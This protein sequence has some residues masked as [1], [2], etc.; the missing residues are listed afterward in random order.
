MTSNAKILVLDDEA[1]LRALLQRYLTQHGFDVRAIGE[2]A[3]IDRLLQRESFDI[4][5]LDIMMRGED[6]LS[7]CQRLRAQKE[8]IPI[9]MLTARGEAVDRILGREVGA[10]DY[11]PKPFDPRELLACINALL[12]RQR[13]LGE[14]QRAADVRPLRLGCFVFDPSSRRL[15]RG[16]ELVSLTSGE[17][18]LLGALA[19]KAGRP[20]SRERL[21]EL[22]KGRESEVTDRSIDVQVLRLRRL[23]EPDPAHPLYLQT[24]RG[25]GYV[26]IPDPDAP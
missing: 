13:M 20:L 1:E 5:I 17:L 24:V 11:L 26:L 22:A 23:I 14:H 2:P 21:I 16:A 12:R 10:D 6:G 4:L 19:M 15:T 9:I 3:L 7:I 25:L 18:S 8:T